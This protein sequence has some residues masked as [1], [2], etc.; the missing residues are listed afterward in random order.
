M[1]PRP[2]QMHAPIFN[3]ARTNGPET[4]FIIKFRWYIVLLKVMVIF[5]D[6][7]ES[8]T[9]LNYFKQTVFPRLSRKLSLVTNTF[10]PG[11]LVIPVVRET[12][13][14]ADRKSELNRNNL[15]L[16]NFIQR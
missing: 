7:Q 16:M 12:E 4:A 15:N 6:K 13:Q 9:T 3:K 8:N 10:S 5:L 14:S 11:W 2:M 1:T